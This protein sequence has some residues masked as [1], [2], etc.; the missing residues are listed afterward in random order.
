MLGFSFIIIFFYAKDSRD[1]RNV[2]TARRSDCRGRLASRHMC[3]LSVFI[4][5]IIYVYTYTRTHIHNVCTV[6]GL[7][8]DILRC[9]R[10]TDWRPTKL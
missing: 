7:A 8:D 2:R 1:N 4:I 5:Y 9:T 6:A 3:L 10:A